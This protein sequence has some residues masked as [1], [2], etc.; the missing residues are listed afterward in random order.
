MDRYLAV[1]LMMKD[2]LKHA[3]LEF[4][5]Y[6]KT[7]DVIYLQQAGEKLFNSFERY[8]EIKYQSIKYRHDDIQYLASKDS[9]NLVLFSQMN[10]LH[11][12]FYHGEVEMPTDVA[13]KIFQ[14]VVQK[15]ESRIN[16]L[17]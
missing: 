9:N 14:S 10:Q 1:K 7:N 4:I 15:I 8:L 13:K 11:R 3:K 12:F 17:R 5:Q 2:M 6:E 16:S